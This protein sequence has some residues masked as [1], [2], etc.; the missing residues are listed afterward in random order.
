MQVEILLM[1]IFDL[2]QFIAKA[3]VEPRIGHV[4]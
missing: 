2:T 3:D 1:V 4:D